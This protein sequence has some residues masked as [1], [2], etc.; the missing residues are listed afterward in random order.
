MEE[1]GLPARRLIAQGPVCSVEQCPCGALYVGCGTVTLCLPRDA[2]AA[3]WETLGESL[4][5]LSVP[6]TSPTM[7][8]P[9]E[10]RSGQPS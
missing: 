5:R 9:T 3:L 7:A 8:L 1:H 4:Q 6:R 2:L 10:G